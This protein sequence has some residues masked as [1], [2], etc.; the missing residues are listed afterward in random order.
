[1]DIQGNT[2]TAFIDGKQVH[3]A[4]VADGQTAG[5]LAIRSMPDEIVDYDRIAVTQNGK[6]IWEDNFDTVDREKWNF[7][8]QAELALSLIHISSYIQ[9]NG[10]IVF[11]N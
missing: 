8:S 5:P 4:T 1:M 7:P 10:K 3:Q 11:K 6:V 9:L 2:I